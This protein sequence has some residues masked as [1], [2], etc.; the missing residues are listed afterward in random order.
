MQRIA[1]VTQ[2]DTLRD[3][4]VAVAGS[5]TVEL[6]DPADSDRSPGQAAQAL[7]RMGAHPESARGSA[8]V[9]LSAA[10]PDVADL[11]HAGRADL[12]AGEAQLQRY[13]ARSA[14]PG[15]RSCRRAGARPT[16][17]PR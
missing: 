7:Q 15:R 17:Y 16:S 9:M 2:A 8:A 12:L 5:G 1:V 13:A 11:E 14:P 3:A 6:D 4:L 10:A